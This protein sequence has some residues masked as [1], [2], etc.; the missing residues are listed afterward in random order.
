MRTWIGIALCASAI[1]AGVSGTAYAA[2]SNDDA[3]IA[4][5]IGVYNTKNVCET[6]AP[7]CI[8]LTTNAPPGWYNVYIVV[9]NTSDSLGVGGLQLSL[10][11]I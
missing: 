5:H 7:A 2:Q 4:A 10:I 11:H 1:V 6:P 8:D 9:G 3:V